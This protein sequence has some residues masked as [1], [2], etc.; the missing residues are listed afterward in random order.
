MRDGGQWTGLAGAII[1]FSMC[2]LR[3]RRWL[4]TADRRAWLTTVAAGR[5]GLKAWN[6]ALVEP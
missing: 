5:L 3:G 4:S 2:G 1:G 6:R